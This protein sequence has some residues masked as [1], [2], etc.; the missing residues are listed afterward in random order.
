MDK[1]KTAFIGFFIFCSTAVFADI[2]ICTDANFWYPFTYLKDNQ[3]AGLHIDIINAALKRVG[4]TPVYKSLPSW[5]ACLDEAKLGLVDA[6][7]TASYRDERAIYLNY[8]A[9]AAVDAESPFRVTQV[10]YV[11]VTPATDKAGR[12]NKYQFTGHFRDIP[13]PIRV[14]AHYSVIYDLEKQGLRVKVGKDSLADFKEML[15]DHTGSVIDV[16]EL[17]RYLATQPEFAGKFKIQSKMLN[18]KS[19]YLAFSKLGRVKQRE[20]EMI[21]EKIARVREDEKMMSEFLKKY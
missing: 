5:K 3:P 9:G 21:W 13:Q 6:V 7:A 8:P 4:L 19:Y 12:P 15:K 1:V 11:I 18:N 2:V 17:G 20:A 14:P 10:G 16:E